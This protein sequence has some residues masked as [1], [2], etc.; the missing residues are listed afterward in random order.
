V[1]VVVSCRSGFHITGD[2]AAVPEMVAQRRGWPR[3]AGGDG[4]DALRWSDVT[5]L[6][7]IGAG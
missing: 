1:G 2:G 3:G 5:A 7:C 4:G 6:S